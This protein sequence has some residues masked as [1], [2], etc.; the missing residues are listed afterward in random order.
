MPTGSE[1][2]EL[3]FVLTGL[4]LGFHWLTFQWGVQST[5]QQQGRQCGVEKKGGQFAVTLTWV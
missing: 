4:G 2:T 1:F 5:V 3:D